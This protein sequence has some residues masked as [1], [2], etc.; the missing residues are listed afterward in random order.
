MKKGAAW[1]SIVGW[2]LWLL[3]TLWLVLSQRPSNSPV[4]LQTIIAS[5]V[6]V[7]VKV[8]GIGLSVALC[9]AYNRGLVIFLAGLCLYALWRYYIGAII[10]RMFPQLGGLS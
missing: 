5:A 1:I 7:G 6:D 10:L 3:L 4:S 8:A 2:S 9:R